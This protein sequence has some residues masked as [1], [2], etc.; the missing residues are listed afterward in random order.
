[1]KN[2]TEGK[3]LKL[4]LMFALPLFVGQLFQLFYSLAD[5]RIV[6]ATL[7]ENALAAV[8]ATSTLSD[9]LMSL[10]NG[11]TNGF[12]I[13]IATYF[14]AQNEKDMK[15]A[16]GGTIFMGLAAAAVVSYSYFALFKYF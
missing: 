6:G 13:I 9:L 15:K 7:G 16:I 8:G 14:G 3:P 4:I 11:I 2:L 1:M 10:L 12:A 5:T